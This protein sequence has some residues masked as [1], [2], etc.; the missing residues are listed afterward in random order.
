MLSNTVGEAL[1]VQKRPELE[2]T[3][4]FIL[5][6][7]KLFD[8]LNV[9]SMEAGRKCR[10]AFKAPYRDNL[11]FRIGVSALLLEHMWKLH[12]RCSVP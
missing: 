4:E 2:R 10:N 5:T 1:K 8:C 9:K 12:P 11:D 6:F 7:D 3:I